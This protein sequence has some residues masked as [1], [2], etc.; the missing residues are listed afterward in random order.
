MTERNMTHTHTRMQPVA[1]RDDKDVEDVIGMEGEAA[2][3][4]H[5][6]RL[7]VRRLRWLYHFVENGNEGMSAEN[8]RSEL[9]VRF[10]LSSRT[11]GEYLRTLAG[12]HL[13]VNYYGRWMTKGKFIELYGTPSAQKSLVGR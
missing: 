4:S 9:M 13:I 6:Q 10:G 3:C 2:F 12:A 8:L 7:R 5:A 1:I 11:A